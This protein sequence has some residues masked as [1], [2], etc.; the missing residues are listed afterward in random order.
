MMKKR[1]ALFGGT[2][3][4]IHLAHTKV[5]HTAVDYLQA[6]RA[7]FIPAKRSPLK[8]SF[9][10]AT[11]E[12]RICM[13]KYAIAGNQ[14]FDVSDYE[15]KGPAP[16]FTLNTVKHFKATFGP[17][18]SLYWLMGADAVRDLCKWYGVNELLD[19]C[20]LTTMVRPCCPKP[21]F[22]RFNPVLGRKKVKQLQANLLETP[23]INISSTQVRALLSQGKDASHF[24]APEVYAYI[25]KERIYQVGR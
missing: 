1:I 16:S 17:A 14:R 8:D 23:L 19:L 24:L 11:D 18:T 13:I 2:F 21:D 5:V 9:P 12:Q 20:T 7:V 10:Q 3:D 25:K 4:P 15:L 6:D 22:S